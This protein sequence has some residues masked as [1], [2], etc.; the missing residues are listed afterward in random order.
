[1]NWQEEEE[2]E[3]EEEKEKEE[4]EE[5][6]GKEEE[7]QTN[8]DRTYEKYKNWQESGCFGGMGVHIRNEK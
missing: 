6:E 4:E 2:E 5:E 1:V 8:L 3:E 7:T